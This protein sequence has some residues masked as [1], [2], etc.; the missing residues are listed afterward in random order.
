MTRNYTI[1]A[2][3]ATGSA[4]V[5]VDFGQNAVIIIILVTMVE[6]SCETSHGAF[7]N[8][9]DGRAMLYISEIDGHGEKL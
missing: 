3:S 8:T 7:N 2:S 1:L 4:P 9:T 6:L 5:R